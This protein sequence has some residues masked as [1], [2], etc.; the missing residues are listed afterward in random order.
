MEAPFAIVLIFDCFASLDAKNGVSSVTYRAF[1]FFVQDSSLDV[2]GSKFCDSA[3]YDQLFKLLR[4][5]APSPASCATRSWNSR[6]RRSRS[7]APWSGPNWA[8]T[9]TSAPV[10]SRVVQRVGAHGDHAVVQTKE[11]GDVSLRSRSRWL[12][13]C[14]MS[15]WISANS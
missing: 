7:A 4:P 13:W 14:R 1:K 9:T 5:P 2:P 3:H 10:S 8:R 12:M 15:P 6:S 11:V